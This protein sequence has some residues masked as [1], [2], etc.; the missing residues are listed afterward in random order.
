MNITFHQ[1]GTATC[2]YGEEIDLSTL[3]PMR[4]TRISEIEW[5]AKNQWWF[6]RTLHNETEYGKILYTNPSREACVQWEKENL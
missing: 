3:G 1:N 5:D 4:C 2:L 6:V